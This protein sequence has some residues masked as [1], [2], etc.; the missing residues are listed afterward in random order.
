MNT[1]EKLCQEVEEAKKKQLLEKKFEERINLYL[2]T[3]LNWMEKDDA[4]QEQYKIDFAHTK[5]YAD[6]VLFHNDREEI[7]IELKEPNHDK[8]PKDIKQLTDYMKALKCSFGLYLGD[9]IELYYDE[10]DKAKKKADPVL[11]ASYEFISKSYDGIELI[12]LLQKETYSSEALETY[13]KNR[14]KLS[15][16]AKFWCT[17]KGKEEIYKF[18]LGNSSLP[19]DLV[20]QLNSMLCIEVSLNEGHLASVVTSVNTPAKPSVTSPSD[21]PSTDKEGYVPNKEV[22][23]LDNI[24]FYPKSRFLAYVIQRLLQEQPNL[25]YAEIEE[26]LP[27]RTGSNKVLVKK[28]D[29]DNFKPDAKG[30]YA[31]KKVPVL[32][33]VNGQVFYVSTQWTIMTYEE[34]VLPV[35][36]KL[37]WQYYRKQK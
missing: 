24:N 18:I 20:K 22:F 9:K 12:K 17:Q 26:I 4:I 3:W 14:I 11:V 25:T 15:S 34:K 16:V 37:G 23:S 10:D 28:E 5:G 13:C 29:W 31:L 7:V 19:E 36:N 32:K 33:D 21:T 27:R 30:R 35:I 8:D 1:W 6:F 2:Q